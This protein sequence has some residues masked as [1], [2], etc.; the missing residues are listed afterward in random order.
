MRW[1]RD[2]FCR[3]ELQQEK[4]TGQDAYDQ[5][6]AL[7]GEISP[8]SD[9]LL[10]LPHLQGSMAPDMNSGAK[11]VFYGA[12]LQHTRAHYIRSIME[13]LGYIICR[14]LEAI[15]AMGLTT[16]EIRTLGGGS[17]SK[18][19]NQIKADITGKRLCLIAETQNTA[20]LGAAILAGVAG[21]VFHSV[22]DACKSMVRIRETYE[23][24]A[25]HHRIYQKQYEKYK[26]LFHLLTP[27]FDEEMR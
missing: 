26:T 10:T 3:Q 27:L 6:T 9:G 4:K 7:A 13:S 24:D 5:M 16:Q 25:A 17:K 21:G 14:N 15:G 8:G 19:W 1:F 12:T 23:P 22:E 2:Q 11:C 20:C 18:I